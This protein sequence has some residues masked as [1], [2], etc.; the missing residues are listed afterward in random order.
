V[1]VWKKWRHGDIYFGSRVRGL[2]VPRSSIAVKRSRKVFLYFAPLFQYVFMHIFLTGDFGSG[3]AP[4][5]A[6][7]VYR[8]APQRVNPK[9]PAVSSVFVRGMAVGRYRR[10]TTTER[11]RLASSTLNSPNPRHPC[12]RVTR[13][14]AA[15][16]AIVGKRVGAY[17]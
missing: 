6:V 12:R 14:A 4:M 1:C 16:R 9:G 17:V 2:S 13:D 8:L 7:D 11:R 10:G 15:I 3:V 5:S